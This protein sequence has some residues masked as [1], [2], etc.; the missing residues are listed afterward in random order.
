MSLIKRHPVKFQL[1]NNRKKTSWPHTFR[2]YHW[3]LYSEFPP[4]H[5]TLWV[6]FVEEGFNKIICK[7]F[8]A[9]RWCDTFMVDKEQVSEPVPSG[10]KSI[11]LDNLL[12][13][14]G[15][16]D[17]KWIDCQIL[18]SKGGFIQ[19]QQRTTIWNLQPWWATCQSLNIK[20]SRYFY[21]GDKEVRSEQETCDFSL[22]E[23]LSGPKRSLSSC[24]WLVYV[25]YF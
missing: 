8:Y 22:A 25:D 6:L 3:F 5:L 2:K 1:A 13:D 24:W 18:F 14:L 21:R 19:S 23:S 7:T 9:L 16:V 20:E 11:P 12:C 15:C 4:N 10:F 17:Q